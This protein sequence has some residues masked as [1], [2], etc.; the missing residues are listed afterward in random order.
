MAEEKRKTMQIKRPEAAKTGSL[1]K[2]LPKVKVDPEAATPETG[3]I[4]PVPADANKGATTRIQLPDEAKIRKA[5]RAEDPKAEEKLPN[6]DQVMEASKNATA[7]IMID[8]ED[9]QSPGQSLK[10]LEAQDDAEKTMRISTGEL[11][12]V[13]G[14]SSTKIDVDS[15]DQMTQEATRVTTGEVPSMQAEPMAGVDRTMKIDVDALQ[16]G[17]VGEALAKADKEMDPDHDKT[18]EIDM[19]ES[20]EPEMDVAAL[21][22]ETVMMETGDIRAA[23]AAAEKAEQNDKAFNAATMALDPNEPAEELSAEK[24]QD[25]FNAMTMAMDPSEIAKEMAKATQP[26]AEI[27]GIEEANE[28]ERPKTILIKR[29]SREAPAATGAP[30]V[31]TVRPDAQTVRTVR[32]GGGEAPAATEGKTVKLRRP[33]GATGARPGAPVSRVASSAGLTIGEDGS[34]KS[35]APAKAPALGGGWLAISIV[36]FLLTVGAAWIGYSVNDANMPMMGR[37][38][39]VDNNILRP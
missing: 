30:T 25:S 37:I 11:E 13:D 33:G 23:A 19:V 31:R 2:P 36:T 34:V 15:V 10:N 17:D 3:E 29:P 24:M 20:A 18:M 5:R 28:E 32:P 38:V 4:Q 6:A 14:G 1:K 9:V 27:G 7:Q 35:T 16:T 12:E 21:S 22:K 26:K 8:V 39:D